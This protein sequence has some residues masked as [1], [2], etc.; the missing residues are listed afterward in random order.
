MLFNIN[1]MLS[2]RFSD[3]ALSKVDV[4]DNI[5]GLHLTAPRMLLNFK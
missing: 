1:A 2:V 3:F 4:T 5:P